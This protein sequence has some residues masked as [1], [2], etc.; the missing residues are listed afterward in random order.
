MRITFRWCLIRW[1]TISSYF[2]KYLKLIF[3]HDNWCDKDNLSDGDKES[4]D[5]ED[6]T[7]CTTTSVNTPVDPS[8]GNTYYYGCNHAPLPHTR[9]TAHLYPVV[10]VTNTPTPDLN[11]VNDHR[12]K[13][14]TPTNNSDNKEKFRVEVLHMV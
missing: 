1:L 6:D 14:T 4:D 10:P 8:P 7:K 12:S 3:P 11:R 5:D 13:V 2:N 9:S